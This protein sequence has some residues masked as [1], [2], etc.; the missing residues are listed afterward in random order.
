MAQ[1]IKRG[2]KWYS[3]YRV[4]Q[5]RIRRAL[6]PYKPEA[7]RK[8]SELLKL[9]TA[10]RHGE[11][12]L[13]MS[14][15]LFQQTYLDESETQSDRKTFLADRRSF[16]L[17]NDAT[18]L[19]QIGQMT[20]DR[21]AKVKVILIKSGKF[22]PS[23]IVR[24]I[25]GM[26][27]AMRWA[28]DRKLV[29]MQNWR[30]VSKTNV[31]PEGRKDYYHRDDYLT[32]L[33]KLDGPWLTSALLM[34][35]A[36]LRLGEALFLEWSDVNPESRMIIFRSKPQYGWTIK[37]DTKLKK[38][39][40]IP[41]VTAD[42]R[43]HLESIRRPSGFVLELPFNRREDV[44]SRNFTRALIETGVKTDAGRLGH[45]HILRHTFG[46][47]LAQLGISLK[48]IAEWM[49][50]ESQ[51]MTEGYAHLC[52]KDATRDIN[53]VE[54]LESDWGLISRLDPKMLGSTLVPVKNS[55]QSKTALLG[56]LG[57]EMMSPNLSSET[58]DNT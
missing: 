28:E 35:R 23:V 57:P 32:L 5:K 33:K 36:G 47:H 1:I 58:L 42:L 30:I 44:Y 18:H 17:V 16:E 15:D 12:V 20:P 21:L 40:S 34:G 8:L 49:G 50:H 56:T 53:L 46:S 55:F 11:T 52:Q 45:P 38:I 54:K 39:R 6:S 10:Q 13:D 43:Q 37:K 4:G 25:R 26:I 2:D 27:T 14:W 3:D 24:G 41:M 31:E 19:T 51:R 7:E 9:R 22:T 48:K 29:A